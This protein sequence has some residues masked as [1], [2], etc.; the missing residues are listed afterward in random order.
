MQEII[1]HEAILRSLERA[2]E[3][4]A[5]GYLFHGPNGSGK[6][7]VARR[8]AGELLAVPDTSLDAHP[9]FVVLM[10]EDG[11]RDIAVEDVRDMI[12]RMHLTSAK[13]GRKVALIED[14]ERLNEAG[15][16]TLL[17]IVE[18]P[19]AASVFLF[20]AE[21]PERL[22]ATLRSRLVSVA[23]RPVPQEEL[24][25]WLKTLSNDAELVARAAQ[26]SRG[27]PGLAKR[28]LEDPVRWKSCEDSARHLLTA[29]AS[30]SLGRS[31]SEID[32]YA[33]GISTSSDPEFAWCEG[34]SACER[35][36]PEIAASNPK[37]F[38]MIGHGI[39]LARR[40]VGGPLSPHLGLEWALFT[41]YYE[42]EIPSFLYPS[43][44]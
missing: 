17:K 23:F 26:A 34:L 24:R 29:M 39:V 15:M 19:D 7:L 13:G 16:N 11:K 18:E 36:L 35:L 30:G 33:R 21:Q 44:L 6:S 38:S 40:F 1:G 12:A 22:P 41:P 2:V 8:F 10:R 31:I 43:Y 42:G 20:I 32:R 5:P 14:A 9:D 3:F 25:A 28:L 27:R 37:A 4:S